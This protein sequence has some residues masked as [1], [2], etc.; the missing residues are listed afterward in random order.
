M[1]P[2]SDYELFPSETWEFSLDPSHFPK[3]YNVRI[4]R[5]SLSKSQRVGSIGLTPHSP[6]SSVY[7]SM[8]VKNQN[9][10]VVALQEEIKLNSEGHY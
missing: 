6:T 10:K 1:P 7:R 2:P 5:A 4:R 3:L 8:E 9:S